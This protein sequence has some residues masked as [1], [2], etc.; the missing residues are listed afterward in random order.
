M[1]LQK[2]A[3][4]LMELR[5]RAETLRAQWERLEAEKEAR[6]QRRSL[7]QAQAEG[8]T[9]GGHDTGL[10]GTR[11]G[12]GGAGGETA[13][14]GIEDYV[15]PLEPDVLTPVAEVSSRSAATSRIR[16]R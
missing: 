6:R 4:N 15:Q 9:P 12:V 11:G 7:A 3:A 5:Q 13:G 16:Q 14:R 10:S 2:P 1:R 8:T